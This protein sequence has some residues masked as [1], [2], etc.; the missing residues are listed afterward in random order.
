MAQGHPI[1]AP[2]CSLLAWSCTQKM[3]AGSITQLL[4]CQAVAHGLLSQMYEHLHVPDTR[5]GV[6]MRR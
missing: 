3:L 5:I 1:A 2:L 6:C 4:Q